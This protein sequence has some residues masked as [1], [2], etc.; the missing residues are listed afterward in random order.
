MHNDIKN[1]F[2]KHST[3]HTSPVV[4]LNKGNITL[5]DSGNV[6]REEN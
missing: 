4:A 1:Y 2:F 5:L 3:L 6:K